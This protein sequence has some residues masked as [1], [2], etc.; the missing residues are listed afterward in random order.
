[1]LHVSDLLLS[2]EQYNS[3]KVSL[4]AI[5]SFFKLNLNKKNINYSTE[6]TLYI[7]YKIV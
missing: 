1:M 2:S 5:W 4:F 3:F 7:Q 6:F